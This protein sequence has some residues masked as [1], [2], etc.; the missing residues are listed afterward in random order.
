MLPA[1]EPGTVEATYYAAEEVGGIT[2]VP[3][4]PLTARLALPTLAAAFFC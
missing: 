3:F 4:P 2:L 1:E